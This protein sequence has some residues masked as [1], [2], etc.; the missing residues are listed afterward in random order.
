[1]SM[2][3]S[4]RDTAA[5]PHTASSYRVSEG[6]AI[7]FLFHISVVTWFHRR[8]SSSWLNSISQL[9]PRSW[10]LREKPPVA[11][12]LK[13]FPTWTRRFTTVFTRARHWSLS[14]ARRIQ[15][16]PPHP[17]SPRSSLI[18]SFHLCPGLLNGFFPSDSPT[19]TLY[20]FL[21]SPCMLHALP[22][23]SSLTW[24]F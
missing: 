15:S 12:L 14:R 23:L 19:K 16:I 6:T 8:I 13:N 7:G 4:P 11:Q 10:D 1:M 20:A 9:T 3:W 17:I 24:S 21:F 5:R 2:C 22:I 18:L